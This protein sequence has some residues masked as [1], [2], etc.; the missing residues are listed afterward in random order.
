MMIRTDPLSFFSIIRYSH[1]EL[2]YASKLQSC[3]RFITPK[4]QQKQK[5]KIQEENRHK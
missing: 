3:N 2:S 4:C 1:S 5:N